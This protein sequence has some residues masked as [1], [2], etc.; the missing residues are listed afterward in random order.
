LSLRV[1]PKTVQIGESL[2][3][4]WTGI[5]ARLLDIAVQEPKLLKRAL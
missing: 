1:S 5:M 3:K 2:G 4:G